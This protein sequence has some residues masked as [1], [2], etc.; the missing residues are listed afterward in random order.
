MKALRVGIIGCGGRGWAH[1]TGY[2][3]AGDRVVLAACADIHKPAA[4]RFKDNFGF[5][6]IYTD[7]HEMLEKEKLDVVSMCLW[8]KLHCPV[9][10]DIASAAYTPKL[11]N[12]EKP[13]A[14]TYGEALK[15][16]KAC[17]SRGIKMTFCHQR[18][19]GASWSTAKKLLGEGV[20]GKLTRMEMN[21]SNLFDWGTHWFDMMNFFN[22]DIQ[23][24]WVLGNIGCA[25][26]TSVFGARVE[27]AGV[28][29]IKWPNDVTGLMT[30]GSGTSTPYEIRLIGTEG[31]MDI[32]HGR[33]KVFAQG[34][35]WED[36]DLKGVRGDDTVLHILASLDWVQNGVES[37]TCS[38]HALAATE[39]IFATYE[40]SRLHQRV[41]LPLKNVKDSPFLSMLKTGE[42]VC[43][44]WPTF[45]SDDEEAEGFKL[46]YNGKDT[47]GLKMNAPRAWTSKGGLLSSTKE[48]AYVWLDKEIGDFELRFERRLDNRAE[49]D[50][51]FWADPA[52]GPQTGL[53][54]VNADD[55]MEPVSPETS[56]ALREIKA[57]MSNIGAGSGWQWVHVRCA[58]GKLTV[59]AN[60]KVVQECMLDD[61]PQAAKHAR[62]GAIGFY[63]RKN[64]ADLRS[65]LINEL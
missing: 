35:D 3:A 40:S 64:A 63:L 59:T 34:K 52:K 24:S 25:A 11:I 19:Y 61:C 15:M 28:S 23:A 65:I 45:V 26:D 36:V 22:D 41:M 39:L 47:K 38:K 7:Y 18:R 33:I 44:D 8:P 30:T 4:Q 56:G 60:G 20:I 53:Q 10:L 54:I 27:T 14:P 29:Y 51:V 2:K 6:K 42:L 9:V 13:M 49:V 43:P 1:A 46:F 5:K 12:A 16:Y 31:M 32:W 50:V 17:E 55:R 21:T 37:L 62:K 58:K 57:P 48:G